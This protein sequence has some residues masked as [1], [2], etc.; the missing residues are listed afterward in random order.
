VQSTQ[1]LKNELENINL[2]EKLALIKNN[3]FQV[4]Q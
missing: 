1:Q 4:D 3:T 2:E